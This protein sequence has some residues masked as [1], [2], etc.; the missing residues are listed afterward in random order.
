MNTTNLDVKN[1]PFSVVIPAFNEEGGIKVGIETLRA[2]LDG[3]P[4][5]YEIIVVDDGSEDRTAELARNEGVTVLSQPENRG[6]GASLKVGI[7]YSK[8]DIIVITDADGSYPADAIPGLLEDLEG[9][10][11]VVGARIGEKVAIPTVRQ[12][13]KWFLGKLASYLAGRKIPDLNSGLRIMRKP[14][15]MRFK[16]LLPEGFSFTTTITLASLCTGALV[17]YTPINYHARIG[18]SK[19]RPHHAVE[20]LLLIIRTIVYFNPLKVFLPLG[21]VFFIGGLSKFIYDVTVGIVSGTAMIGFL[22]AAIIW[23]VGL[24]S[25]QITKITLR[26]Q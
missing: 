10:Q 25:D 26:P 19:I 13:A 3:G 20:F 4:R 5:E 24:L 18:E 15:I 1:E 17:K 16:H 7:D 11:M 21:G 23:A 12:P 2:A 6:Y 14:L 9:Y 8:F 22:G